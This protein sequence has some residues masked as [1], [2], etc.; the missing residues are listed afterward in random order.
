MKYWENSPRSEFSWSGSL[1][2]RSDNF[3]SKFDSLVSV[4]GSSALRSDSGISDS[5]SLISRQFL[6]VE[7]K[8]AIIC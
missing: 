2:S 8:K 1:A 4:P 6:G 3:D 7:V 5:G